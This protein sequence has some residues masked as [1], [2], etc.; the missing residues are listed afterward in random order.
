MQAQ[1]HDAS[2]CRTQPVMVVWASGA[3]LVSETC[4]SLLSLRTTREVTLICARP[5]KMCG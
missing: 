3:M 5:L 2:R 4:C 1:G